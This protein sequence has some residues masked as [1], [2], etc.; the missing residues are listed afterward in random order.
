MFENKYQVLYLDDEPEDT[1]MYRIALGDDFEFELAK[2]TDHLDGYLNSSKRYDLLL[3]D[4]ELEKGSGNLLGLQLIKPILKKRPNLPIIVVTKDNSTNTIKIAQDEG[5]VDFLM[6][7]DFS[8]K[9]WKASFEKAINIGV[10]KSNQH[11]Q[12]HFANIENSFAFIGASEKVTEIRKVLEFVSNSPATPL[13]I[14]GETG[15]GKEVAAKYLHSISPRKN[16]P[17]VAENLSA[18]QDTLLESTLFGHVKGAFTGAE[19]DREG[20]FM[21]ANGGILMLDEIGDIN[22]DIQKKLLRFLQDKIIKPVGSDKEVKLDVQIIA[23]THR[24]L[25]DRVKK[26][27]FREDF[28]MRLKS[29]A[30]VLPPLRERKE[31]IPL[32]LQHFLGDPFEASQAFSPDAWDI[33]TKFHWPGNIRQLHNAIPPMLYNQFRK[34]QNL[35]DTSCLPEDILREEK[36]PEPAAENIEIDLGLSQ[37]ERSQKPIKQNIPRLEALALLNLQYIEDAMTLKNKV[38]QDVADMLLF[39][40]ADS[41]L[42]DIKTCY[43]DF[44]HLFDNNAFPTIR[45]AYP[46]IF[47]H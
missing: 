2:N 13:L 36:A 1:R 38:K 31:D 18:I 30:I 40:S 5:A 4:L 46:Q 3:L 42:Y 16:K 34:G 14:L 9:A 29:M 11:R 15:T 6:K 35:I 28:Y 45:A 22:E 44:P 39:K 12:Q 8:I 7:D 32:L 20:L 10:L 26:G 43:R 24:D 47:K 41:L 37:I 27:L 19:R 33:I 21:K 17:L 23:A 25:E